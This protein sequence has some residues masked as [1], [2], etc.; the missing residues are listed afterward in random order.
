MK[1]IRFALPAAFIITLAAILTDPSQAVSRLNTPK[2]SYSIP[3]NVAQILKHSCISCH[4]LGGSKMASSI[5]SFSAWDKYSVAK[6]A[7]KAE[8]ICKAMTKGTMPPE[9]AWKANP[10]IIPTAAQV[11]I[12]CKWAGSLPKK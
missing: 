12:V 3:D 1:K 2:A 4:N 10:S 7:T 6:Q 5:W 9:P 8:A 11:N